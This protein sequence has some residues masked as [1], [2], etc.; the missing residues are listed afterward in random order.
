M[1]SRVTEKGQITVPKRL[2]ERLGILPGDQLEL[3][4]EEG[5]LVV[6]KTVPGD[7]DPVAA[8]YGILH[9]DVSADEAIQALR[10][11]PDAE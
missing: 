6:M 11:E 4:E 9:L 2:R 1:L 8:V 7:G 3:V 5:R 10:G